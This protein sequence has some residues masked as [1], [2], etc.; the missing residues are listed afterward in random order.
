MATDSSTNARRA[1]DR[2]YAAVDVNGV[3]RPS[4]DILPDHLRAPEGV[5]QDIH[6]INILLTAI[7][8]N[9]HADLRWL[10]RKSP[11]AAAA[12][13]TTSRLLA[14]VQQVQVFLGELEKFGDI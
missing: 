4:R 11:D 2:L 9:A 5:R 13:K 12:R 10:N 6:E 3:M 1:T 7:I 8:V 14:Q